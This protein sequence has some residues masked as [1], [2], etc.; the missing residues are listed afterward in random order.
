MYIYSKFSKWKRIINEDSQDS[1]IDPLN[2]FLVDL[3][4]F[5]ENSDLSNYDGGSTLLYSAIKN[6][7]QLKQGKTFEISQNGLTKSK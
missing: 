5:F 1:I 6:L 4:F 7:A 2:I 3:F